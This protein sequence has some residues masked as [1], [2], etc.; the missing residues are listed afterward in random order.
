MVSVAPSELARPQEAD[1]DYNRRA[2]EPKPFTLDFVGVGAARSGTSWLARCLAEHP[3]IFIPRAKELHFFDNDTVYN[4]ALAGLRSHFRDVPAGRRLGEFTPRYL[5]S[6]PALER[7]RDA[8]PET[9]ILVCLRDPVERAYSQYCYF[10]HNLRKEPSSDF[11]TAMTG[12]FREDYLVKSLYHPQLLALFEIF[13]RDR[14]YVLEFDR[15]ATDASQ[16]VREVY[17]FLNVASDFVP[18]TAQRKV[19]A[20]RT[21]VTAPP[22]IVARLVRYLTYSRSPVARAA[23]KFSPGAIEALGNG[24]HSRDEARVALPLDPTT[25][26]RVFERYFAEDLER[27]E[28]LLDTDLSQWKHSVG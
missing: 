28:A 6:R 18:A 7:I 12:F 3:E 5:I 8:F 9:R 25:R 16:V 14:V 22:A 4:P 1:G 11:E 20:S 27:T 17:R 15:I 24:F 2:M 21:E 19:N 13:A 10:R 26:A 23:R